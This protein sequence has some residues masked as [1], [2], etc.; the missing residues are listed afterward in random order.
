M[1]AE[2]DTCPFCGGALERGYMRVRGSRGG[3]LYWKSDE[4]HPIEW[5]PKP[6]RNTVLGRKRTARMLLHSGFF[7]VTDRKPPGGYCD[8]CGLVVAAFPVDDHEPGY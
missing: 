5:M 3:T 7:G 6:L 1:A 4:Q 2:F 8:A